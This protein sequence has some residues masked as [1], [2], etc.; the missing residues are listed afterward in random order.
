MQGF[1][2][3]Y[4]TADAEK[5]CKEENQVEVCPK[6][7]Q[8]VSAE[9]SCDYDISSYRNGVEWEDTDRQEKVCQEM[10]TTS[11]QRNASSAETPTS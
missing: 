6:M 8:T 2:E 9:L 10:V 7:L 3:V 4:R 5:V 11:D 1:D